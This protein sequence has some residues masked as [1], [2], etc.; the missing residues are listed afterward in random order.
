M[1]DRISVDITDP[2]D[3]V[4]EDTFLEL[5]AAERQKQRSMWG[6][7]HD[8][9]HTLIEWSGIIMQEIAPVLTTMIIVSRGA[10]A[11]HASYWSRQRSL[12]KVAAVAMAWFEAY[13][14]R[15]SYL[16]IRKRQEAAERG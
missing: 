15:R 6:D 12:V 5:V 11:V 13:H 3:A 8:D 2:A 4:T 7:H 1:T 14:R 9:Q 16:V 10:E